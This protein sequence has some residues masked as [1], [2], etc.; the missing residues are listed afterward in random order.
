MKWG[1]RSA[2]FRWADDKKRQPDVL[3][4]IRQSK[5]KRLLKEKVAVQD[6]FLL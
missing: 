1:N 5:K 2:S 3:I 6:R 4:P